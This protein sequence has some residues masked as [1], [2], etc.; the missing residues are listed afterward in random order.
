MCIDIYEFIW[1]KKLLLNVIQNTFPILTNFTY[2]DAYFKHSNNITD[3]I[4]L[5]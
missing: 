2:L 3:D 4:V 5:K 1:R